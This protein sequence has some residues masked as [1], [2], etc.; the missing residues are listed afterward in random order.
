[1]GLHAGTRNRQRAGAAIM[2]RPRTCAHI[3]QGVGMQTAN[4]LGPDGAL[5]LAGALE[6]MMGMQ[7]LHLVSHV[8][9]AV[10]VVDTGHGPGPGRLAAGPPEGPLCLRRAA[11]QAAWAG[12]SV[13]M[14]A[15]S[16]TWAGW[17]ACGRERCGWGELGGTPHGSTW[18]RGGGTGGLLR[19]GPRASAS[20]S[21]N[22]QFIPFT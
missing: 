3:P 22:Q 5:F 10:L 21:R 9:R 17:K 16:C 18:L 15:R 11:E 8:R 6:K 1:M 12:P 4:D 14:C 20:W 13:V 2:T 7:T 19:Q